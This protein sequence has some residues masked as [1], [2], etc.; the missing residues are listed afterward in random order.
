MKISM[1]VAMAKNGVIGANN[2]IP[3]HLP[4]DLK[5][6][7]R[8]TTGHPI[9]MGR[10]TFESLPNV[11]PGRDHIIITRNPGYKES[12]ARARSSDRVFIAGTPMEAVDM[13]RERLL[14]GPAS[15]DEVFV[16]GGSEIFQ[17]MMPFADR[18]YLSLLKEEFPGDAFFPTIEQSQWQVVESE[19]FDRFDF[20]VYDRI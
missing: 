10:R 17:Q 8:L 1:I 6:F 20:I 19:A 11:L 5:K 4:E 15:S 9:L 2:S 18:I 7:R 13:A 12:N 14:C 16:I 3:W